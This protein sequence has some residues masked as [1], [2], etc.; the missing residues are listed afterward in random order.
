MEATP[1]TSS[2]AP[3]IT[4]LMAMLLEQAHR[5]EDQVRQQEEQAR[6]LKKKAAAGQGGADLPPER[7]DGLIKRHS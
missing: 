1:S 3:D 7:A 4:A 2:V 6:W 5:Q